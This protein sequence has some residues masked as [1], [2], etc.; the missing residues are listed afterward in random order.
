MLKNRRYLGEYQFRDEINYE[1]IPPL[2]DPALFDKCQEMLAKNKIRSASFKKLEEKYL[3]TGKIFCGHCDD[4]ISGD[5]G[6]SKT[7]KL[8][9]YYACRL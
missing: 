9:R 1:A 5:S 2:I 3:L 7:G 8:Y 4:T 6:K